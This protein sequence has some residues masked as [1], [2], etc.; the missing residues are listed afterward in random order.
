MNLVACRCRNQKEIEASTFCTKTLEFQIIML[1]FQFLSNTVSGYAGCLQSIM[2]QAL[3]YCIYAVSVMFQC[4]QIILRF[5]TYLGLR[6]LPK[7]VYFA[8]QHMSGSIKR[9]HSLVVLL[10][11]YHALQTARRGS[12]IVHS[13][14]RTTQKQARHGFKPR[15]DHSSVARRLYPAAW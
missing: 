14:T 13:S 12:P 1:N 6:Y 4:Q 10:Y 9:W 8:H 7:I 2:R 11:L 5:R 15:K 3:D